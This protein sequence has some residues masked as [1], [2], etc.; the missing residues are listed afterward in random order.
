MNKLEL[1]KLH[2]KKK[3]LILGPSGS[4]K[5]Y[6]C[7]HYL[8]NSKPVYGLDKIRFKPGFIM[9]DKQEIIAELI[10]ISKTNNFIIEGTYTKKLKPILKDVDVIIYIDENPFKCVFRVV[11]RTIKTK[12][13]RE[14]IDFIEKFDLNY[15]KFLYW[16]LTYHKE[17]QK[18]LKDLESYMGKYIEL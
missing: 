13:K 1:E 4:G 18:M 2:N 9:R 12:G 7:K 6:L 16:V 10:R 14:E 8:D 11:M 17:K 5:S 15:L 3:I